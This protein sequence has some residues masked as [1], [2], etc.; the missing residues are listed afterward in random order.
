MNITRRP[1]LNGSGISIGG[2]IVHI[3]GRGSLINGLP[4]IGFA[5]G[6]GINAGG[7]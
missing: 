5:K 3:I 7:R 1:K 2:T 4:S 6:I